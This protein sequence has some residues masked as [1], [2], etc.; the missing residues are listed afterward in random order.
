MN[1]F[2]VAGSIVA[3]IALIIS[4][5][6]IWLNY[7]Y[8][9]NKELPHYKIKIGHEHEHGDI[10]YISIRVVNIGK[11]S[12]VIWYQIDWP[13][14]LNN[15]YSQEQ[16][17]TI[18]SEGKKIGMDAIS[19]YTSKEEDFLFHEIELKPHET[20]NKLLF[21]SIALKKFHKNYSDAE[22]MFQF[23]DDADHMYSFPLFKTMKKDKSIVYLEE[24]S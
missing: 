11:I 16:T 1:F 2:T 17:K 9:S 6:N 15:N 3:W 20:T 13:V 8:F 23:Q 18:I 5:L 12:T 7:K 24:N 19:N 4:I 10:D 21:D 14:F 22:I